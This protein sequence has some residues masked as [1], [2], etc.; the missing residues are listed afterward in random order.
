MLA[1]VR[2]YDWY[3]EERWAAAE[4]ALASLSLGWGGSKLYAGTNGDGGD[5][6]ALAGE[7]YDAADHRRRLAGEGINFTTDSQAELCLR[8]FKRHGA[9]FFAAVNGKFAVAIWQAEPRRLTLIADRFGMLPCYY[10]ALADGLA[11]GSEITALLDAGVVPR[12][13]NH[14]AIATFFAF[15]QYMGDATM[16]AGIRRL[17]PAGW[18]TYEAE[19]NRL[20]LGRYWDSRSLAQ[21]P[22]ADPAGALERI[23]HA[24]MAA[25]ARCA[26]G[27]EGL[28]LSLSGGLDSRTIMAGVPPSQPLSCVTLGTAGGMDLRLA[29]RLAGLAGRPFHQ[30]VLGA[31]FLR[32]YEQHL[33]RMI[34]LTEA[35]TLAS[36]ITVPTIDLYRQLGIRVLLRGHGGELMHMHRA[37]SCS[38]DTAAFALGDAGELETWAFRHLAAPLFAEPGLVFLTPRYRDLVEPMGRA[39]LH[40]VL[41]ELDGVEPLVHRLWLLFVR[42]LLPHGVAPSIVKYVTVTEIRMPYVDA[43]LIAALLSA[44][45]TL[46][47]GDRVQAHLLRQ[48]APGLLSVPDTNTGAPLGAAPRRAALSLFAK[49][50]LAKLGVPGY[51]PYERLGLW[52]RREELGFVER[53]LL[54]DRCLD[55]GV[56]D[57]GAVRATIDDHVAKRQNNTYLILGMLNFELG[58]RRFIDAEG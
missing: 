29:G 22:A 10:A 49:R 57:R 39:A 28:G 32:D 6:A 17:P 43:D 5:V 8:G 1:P 11:F 46:K 21:S 31:E 12:R 56:F 38:L 30:C 37:Y 51:Q 20:E 9:G 58:Q 24:F 3:R 55:R 40:D 18:L 23:D 33:G 2:H 27:A 34:Q 45:P 36:G 47:L 4:T 50:A 13:P 7:I 54:S 48:H 53:V 14:E 25:V 41:G 15:R 19:A 42:Q 35:Q 16:V 44:P 52:L 26:D